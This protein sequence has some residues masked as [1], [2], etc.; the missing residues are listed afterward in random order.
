MEQTVNSAIMSA[1]ISSI[2]TGVFGLIGQA[3]SSQS[4]KS[5]FNIG[6][7]LIHVG[8][9]QLI[10]NV[11]GFIIGVVVGSAM[12]QDPTATLEDAMDSII[13]V[14]LIVG[15]IL[16]IVCFAISGSKVDRAHRWQHLFFVAVG[17]MVSTLL[18]NSFLL[19]AVM[20]ADL[21]LD[22]QTLVVSAIQSFVCMIIGGWIAD[23]VSP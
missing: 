7:A 18:I 2:F 3:L 1:V 21:P 9:I 8:V 6:K 14:T 15:S 23:S 13:L 10:A 20:G 17:V 11:A 16:L 12:I 22:F 19:N 4:A 5:S